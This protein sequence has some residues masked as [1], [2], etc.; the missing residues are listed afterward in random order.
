MDDLLRFFGPRWDHPTW[1][2]EIVFAI[3]P[4]SLFLIASGVRIAL[5][6]GRS[7]KVSPTHRSPVRVALLALLV[8]LRLA[9]LVLAAIDSA[10]KASVLAA[11]FDFLAAN[12][13]LALSSYEHTRSVA[14]S[15]I[16]AL[17]LV[18]TTPLDLFRAQMPLFRDTPAEV[19]ATVGL[20]AVALKVGLI[21]SE[22]SSKRH[23]LLAEYRHLSP[24]ATSGPYSRATLWW[25]N[26]LLGRGYSND[27]GS[28]LRHDEPH[29]YSLLQ[30]VFSVLR[31]RFVAAGLPQV[32]L[33]GFKFVQPV[34]IRQTIDYVTDQDTDFGTRGSR[35]VAAYALVYA[36][37]ALLGASSGYRMTRFIVSLRGGLVSLIY[38]KTL[39]LSST[40]GQERAALTLMSTDVERIT[41][42][43]RSLHTAWTAV[44]EVSVALYLLYTQLGA[45]F[46]APGV[47]FACA[48]AAM[49]VCTRLFPRF[50]T[51]WVE[52]IGARIAST[53]AMLGAIRSIRLL[54]LSDVVGDLTHGLRV[55]E[56][57]VARKIRSLIVFQVVFQNITSIA[58]P[59]ATLAVYIIHA[60]AGAT[61]LRV[62]TAF[63][64]L[65]ILQLLEPPLMLLFQ[66]LPGLAASLACF[67][68]IQT[69]LLTPSREDRRALRV[70]EEG[71]SSDILTLQDCSFGW[72]VDEPV[73]RNVNLSV[74]R[75]SVVMVIG[76]TGGGKSTLLK[77]ILGETPYATGSVTLSTPSMGFADQEPWMLNTTIRAGICGESPADEAL[78][79]AVIDACGLREDLDSLPRRDQ[80]VV[81]SKGIALSGGQKLRLALARAVFARKELL[82]LDDVFSGLD[83][84]TEEQIFRALFSQAGPWRRQGTSVVL[85]THAVARLAYADWIVV[86]SEDGRISEQGTYE[87]L[88]A[89]TGYVSGLAVNFKDTVGSDDLPTP[90]DEATK[91][92]T[93]E[94]TEIEE[95]PKKSAIKQGGDWHTFQHY[96]STA[97]WGPMGLAA[98]WS[99][100]YV[101]SIKAPGLLIEYFT[102][103]DGTTISSNT[104]FIIALSI[105]SVVSLISLMALVWGLFLDI[106]P[107]VSNGMHRQ[108]LDTVLRAPLAFF[109]V[110]DSGTTLNRFSEDLT[111]ID[112]ELPGVL[113]G[114]MLQLALFFIGGAIMAATSSYLITTIPF[115]IAALIAVQ[116]FYLQTSRQ[117]RQLNLAYKAPLYTHFQETLSG[118]VSVRAFGWEEPFGARNA[119]LL[120]QSQRPL[121][122]LRCI[123]TWLGLVL[124][125]LV[126]AL[127]TILMM[128]IA[129]L[130]DL[131]DPALVGLGLLNVMSFNENLS[132]LIQVWSLTETSIGAIARVR[133]FVAHTDSENKPREVVEPSTDWP[134]EGAVEISHVTASYSGSSDPVLQDITLNIRPGE[135]IGICGRSGSGKSS[136]LASL[137]H[138]LEYRGGSI[139]IDGQDLAQVPRNV[140]RQRLNA[141]SQETYWVSTETVRFNLDPWG[142][143]TQDDAALIEA[144][145]KCQIW[146]VIEEKGGLNMRMDAEFLSH[147]QR[148]LFCLARSLLRKSRIVVLD[149][150]SAS[151]DVK[152]DELLQAVI[153][154]EFHGCTII[155]VA[156]RLNTIVDFDRVV[157]LHGGQVVESGAPQDLLAQDGSRF[158]EL[159]EM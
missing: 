43:F 119:S 127:G 145:R 120:D 142:A 16:I 24:E 158:K 138:L 66:E 30:V 96:F 97:G 147:G 134:A 125:L 106:I 49:T 104:R 62:S 101:T 88:R 110:T 83:A 64:I 82:L 156:H 56:N 2:Q 15:A 86:L 130:P 150:V 141:I 132:E 74:P 59:L 33:V 95:D 94:V 5:L 131:V 144:L 149:E 36:G 126:A 73:L 32:L 58:A 3:A 50:Q 78:Y 143:T 51:V 72:T 105:T 151:V 107:R 53:A 108:L 37:L 157:V 54:G 44:I 39:A 70:P 80:T 154:E 159:Y 113:I 22:A 68:R 103:P 146:P 121:Y 87:S 137:F 117:I 61:R 124:N 31:W 1:L 136:L 114:T 18:V 57:V 28:W 6:K 118:L 40:A 21:F 76:P 20:V 14:P 77:G 135:K 79:Q 38:R 23:L 10:A 25:I 52:A 35:L 111:V 102:D 9:I 116:R 100:V 17:Y 65:S 47:C 12:A 109:T 89:N 69:F 8:V 34:L 92:S 115:V 48:V 128:T 60:T 75:G 19:I 63:S 81:G 93:T 11:A 122:L 4:A 71:Q 27:L 112:N 42:A 41:V 85:V 13:L 140:L 46:I 129:D 153:R 99:L 26:P 29:A 91:Q 67:T 123:Q 84:D 155:A 90:G 98:L 55:R 139:T 133:D 148:Q 152:T 45:G 7:V